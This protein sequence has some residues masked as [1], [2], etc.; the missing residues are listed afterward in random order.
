[1]LA[2]MNYEKGSV[3]RNPH[4]FLFF[5]TFYLYATMRYDETPGL[6][7]VCVRHC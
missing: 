2:C 6:L 3:F 5:V 7:V 1:M 4:V